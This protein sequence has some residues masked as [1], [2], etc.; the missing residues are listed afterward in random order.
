MSI[1]RRLPIVSLVVSVF[2]VLLVIYEGA[3]LGATLF[4][5]YPLT[6]CVGHNGVVL[7][8]LAVLV[9]PFAFLV[10]SLWSR[11]HKGRWPWDVAD[12]NGSVT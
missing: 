7:I 1:R 12:S 9:A 4:R 2:A 6:A 3:C 5:G 8:V 10:D 11:V